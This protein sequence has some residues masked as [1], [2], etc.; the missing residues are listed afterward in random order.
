M[1][2]KRD[3][4]TGRFIQRLR[5]L[6]QLYTEDELEKAYEVALKFAPEKLDKDTVLSMLIFEI[7]MSPYYKRER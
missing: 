5:A 7:E 6:A 1:A 3:T 2:T 4:T